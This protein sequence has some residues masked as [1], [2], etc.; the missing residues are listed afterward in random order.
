MITQPKFKASQETHAIKSRALFGIVVQETTQA[1]GLE[2][3]TSEASVPAPDNF[4]EAGVL[5]WF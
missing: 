5:L 4:M 3:V 1:S 2:I